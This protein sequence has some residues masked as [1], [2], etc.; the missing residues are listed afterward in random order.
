MVPNREEEVHEQN[1]KKSDLG[2]ERE[3]LPT[4]TRR[5]VLTVT[6]STATCVG[7]E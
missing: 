7:I 4:P 3:G 1:G 2:R 5:Q 6:P